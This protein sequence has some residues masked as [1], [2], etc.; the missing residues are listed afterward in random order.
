MA[1]APTIMW[2]GLS[3]KEY[4]YWIYPIGTSF[5]KEP[6][7]YIFAKETRSGYWL[8]CYIGQTENLDERLGDH[9]KEACAKRNGATHIQTHL[10]SGG[11]VVRKAE[12]KDLIQKRKPPCNEQLR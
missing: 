8:P 5:K 10:A 11:E 12:E 3:G 4:K 2:R 9:E 7:N 6:G 1:E